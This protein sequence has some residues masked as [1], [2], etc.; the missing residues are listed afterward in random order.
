M[1]TNEPS[2]PAG[3]LLVSRGVLDADIDSTIRRWARRSGWDLVV[4]PEAG[5]RAHPDADPPERRRL[6]RADA[7]ALLAALRELRE[8]V[9]PRGP[10][11]FLVTHEELTGQA[12]RAW[13]ERIIEAARSARVPLPRPTRLSAGDPPDIAVL[14]HHLGTARV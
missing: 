3:V 2:T 7:R 11:G 8:R 12:G 4:L 10:G 6:G 5:Y 13:H 14:N 9:G 1:T